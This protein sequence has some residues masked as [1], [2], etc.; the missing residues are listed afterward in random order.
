MVKYVLMDGELVSQQ[1]ACVLTNIRKA[2]TYFHIN[3]GHRTLA[4][5]SYFWG[6]YTCQ[7]CNNGNLA[8]RPTPWAPHI[9]SGRFDHAIDFD[10]VSGVIAALRQ[11]G[12]L[13][14]LTVPG[15]SWHVEADASQLDAYFKAHKKSALDGL[16][17]HVE[18]AAKR[19]IA[20]RNTVRDTVRDRDK[21]DSKTDPKKWMARDEAVQQ[22]V[23]VRAKR[24]RRL[25]RM[26]KRARKDST[27][28]VL[29]KVLATHK[30]EK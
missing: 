14:R 11:R 29:R 8:A 15:E 22:A 4:R 26:L 19:F 16:P 28:R 10:N 12:I 27:R 6:C 2:G 20:A 3:E 30:E 5:Q 1:W 24:R 13:A 17:K 18:L 7:C 23:K 21:V 25:E 9:R